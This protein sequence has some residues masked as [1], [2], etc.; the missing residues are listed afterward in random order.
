MLVVRRRDIDTVC[1]WI[2]VVCEINK[3][4]NRVVREIQWGSMNERFVDS[5]QWFPHTVREI[6]IA[7]QE[8]RGGF[9][10]KMLPKELRS[11]H[12]SRVRSTFRNISVDGLPERLERFVM[13]WCN[14][15]G[16]MEIHQINRSLKF[17]D[18]RGNP[19][20]LVVIGYLPQTLEDILF[21][22]PSARIQFVSA[23]GDKIDP[24]VKPHEMWAKYK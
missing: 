17:M 2:G 23:Y 1:R 11:L 13:Q 18:F 19:I 9:H 7:N 6:N 21:Y 4:G 14:V 3:T 24:R 15:Q 5:L 8:V 20:D 22:S 16:Y 10:A 12:L